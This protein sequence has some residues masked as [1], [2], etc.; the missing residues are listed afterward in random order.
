MPTNQ[1][2]GVSSSTD[3]LSSQAILVC[4]ALTTTNQH[5]YAPDLGSS[6]S[7][8][9]SQ[10]HMNQAALGGRVYRLHWYEWWIHIDLIMSETKTNI[11]VRWTLRNAQS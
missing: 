1:S 9:V 11:Q 7:M 4:I 10:E 3:V 6:L 8:F 5:N 2:D